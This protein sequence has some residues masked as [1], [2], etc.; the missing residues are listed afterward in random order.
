M[1]AIEDALQA[2]IA[3][4]RL[5]SGLGFTEGPIW[6]DGALEFTDIPGDAILRYADGDA[7]VV[8]DNAH[9]AI[10]L[11]VDHEGRRIACE[12]TTRRVTRTTADGEP[13]VLASHLGSRVLNSPNDVVVRADGS[14]WFTDPPFGVR[15]EGGELHGYQQA[16]ELP[17]CGVFRVTD[18]PRAPE[19]M[20]T[21]IYRPN[22]LIFDADER[23]L[24]VSD[25]SERY[26]T[27]FVVDVD[28]DELGDPSP[29][30]VLPAGVPDGMAFDLEGH[31]YV[32]GLDGVY[33]YATDGG[34]GQDP[35]LGRI[36]VPEMVTNCCFGGADGRTLFIT[37][38]SS[39]YAAE[40]PVA[41]LPVPP[42]H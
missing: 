7:T 27:I 12:H 20:L 5:V 21:G 34:P 39:L 25:S 24:F 41:G 35:L 16:M 22:G 6:R 13:E 10:G 38:T 33:V 11:T 9:F 18:D 23:R 14:I 36:D 28:G 30:A 31:L 17:F 32:A 4:R 8:V 3:T 26:R 15:A 29:F 19:P 42:A 40:L 2:G 37:A 1:S